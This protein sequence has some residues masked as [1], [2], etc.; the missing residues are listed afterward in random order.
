MRKLILL[1]GIFL[2]FTF[3]TAQDKTKSIFDL[4]RSGTVAEVKDM[5]KQ[6]PD[7][8]NQ[9]NESGFSPLILAC[10]RGNVE[11]AKFLIDN[12]KDVNYKSQEGTALS[13]LSVKY[14]KDL[15]TYL[16]NKK[17][18]PNIADATGSTPLF[19][20]V[21]FGNKELIELLLRYKADKTLKDA[22]GMT[23]FE[24][25]LQTNNKEIINLL[26]N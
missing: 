21:K 5:M 11:V 20:A 26:K 23:P 3:V 14:N 8:I 17:A 15:V 9:T 7:I 22:Q 12:V 16:L 24:Y 25:A 18:D 1:M 2:S 6:N 4:A 10:Y 19:W 13:G